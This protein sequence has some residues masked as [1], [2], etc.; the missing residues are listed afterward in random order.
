MPEVWP[1]SLLLTIHLSVSN[2]NLHLK[3]YDL[4]L[5]VMNLV[6]VGG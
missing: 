2:G 1:M 3:V 5:K 4:F 6:I